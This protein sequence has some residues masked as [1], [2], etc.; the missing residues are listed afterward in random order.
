MPTDAKV[1]I[2]KPRR[3]GVPLRWSAG[4][5]LAWSAAGWMRKAKLIERGRSMLEKK[6]RQRR[7]HPAGLPID[8]PAATCEN[9]W[10]AAPSTGA[11]KSGRR[12][13]H[14]PRK[15]GLQIR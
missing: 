12:T 6:R 14:G 1:L 8:T 4:P 5:R 7:R 11:S 2:L 10:S 3:S 13:S 9:Y 15:G